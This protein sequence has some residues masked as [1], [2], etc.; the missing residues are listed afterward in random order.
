MK[1]ILT[2]CAG[3][4]GI[5]GSLH[6]QDTNYEVINLGNDQTVTFSQMIETVE[7]VVGKKGLIDRQPEQPGDVPQTWADIIKART[8][9]G[10][11]PKIDFSTGIERFV[12]WRNKQFTF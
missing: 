8:L 3:F 10:Y 2:G 4:N 6:Y 5:L 11:E 1:I 9:L 12:A 7:V